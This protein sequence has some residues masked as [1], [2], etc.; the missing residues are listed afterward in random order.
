MIYT[1][2]WLERIKYALENTDAGRCCD[3]V[4][5]HIGTAPEPSSSPYEYARLVAS[6]GEEIV[7]RNKN[8]RTCTKINV[9]QNC[10]GGKRNG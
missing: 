3:Y 10:K 9:L 8:K 7:N 4:N 5:R 6:I 2:R 1:K